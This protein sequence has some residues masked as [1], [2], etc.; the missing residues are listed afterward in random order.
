MSKKNS[1]APPMGLEMIPLSKLKV[2]RAAE[3]GYARSPSEDRLRKRR[4]DWDLRKVGTI[5]V[6]QRTDGTLWLI[7]GQHRRE[8]ALEMGIEKLPALVHY[9]LTPEEEADLYL[10][11]ADALPQQALS[12]FM[13]RLRR[14]DREAKALKAAVEGVGLKIGS[15]YRM[16][17]SD[18]GTVIAIGRLE[19]IYTTAG[20]TGLREVLLLAKEAWGL[21]HRAYQ[22]AMLEAVFQ[23]WIA[24]HTLYDRDRLLQRMKEVGVEGVL[25]KAYG[26]R[27]QGLW[28]KTV[29]SLG[30]ALWAI[31]HEPK[32]RSHRLPQWTGKRA[33]PLKD[34][35]IRE[36]APGSRGARVDKAR[37]ER[38]QLRIVG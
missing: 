2:D 5:E 22:Q 21:D 36:F 10:G 33:R 6:S 25:A 18:D 24:F 29:D 28:P 32:L 34:G 4:K 26:L 11:K 17:H 3:G 35:E 30:A 12:Q 13:A 1:A 16:A 37:Q 9:G 14:G 38:E 19:R 31:Y 27:S 20:G 23:F 8:V 7:D 15:D